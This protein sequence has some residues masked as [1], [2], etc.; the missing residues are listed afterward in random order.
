MKKIFIGIDFS[1]KTF[2][3]TVLK[4]NL[5]HEKGE[6]RQFSNNKNGALKLIEWVEKIGA[7]EECLFCGEDTGF[8]S[9]IVSETIVNEGCFMW[10]DSALRIKRSLGISREKNDKKDSRDIALYAA[11]FNDRAECYVPL[12]QATEALKK[13][14]T[15]RKQLMKIYDKLLV[16]YY[17]SKR[18]LD[19]ELLSNAF[20]VQEELISQVKEKIKE[21]DKQIKKIIESNPKLN[22]TFEILTSMPGIALINATAFIVYTNNFKKFNYDARKIASFWG[23]APFGHTS[24][25]SIKGTP[26]VSHYADSYLKSLLSEAA[27]CASRYCPIIN[28]YVTKLK[29]AGKHKNIVLN[30]AKNKMIHILVAMVRNNEN[31]RKAV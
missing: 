22:K 16:N 19:N 18:Y 4:A 30:N 10:L 6:H 3:A 20:A 26:H 27:L 23:V 25:T 14:F 11:R 9:K 29:K 28:R 8:Y 5:L 13:I 24:G 31:Y 1:K 7:R 17:E 15:M 2:D 12:D 21:L